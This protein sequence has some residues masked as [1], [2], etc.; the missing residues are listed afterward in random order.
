[1]DFGIGSKVKTLVA[2][3][4]KGVTIAK[5]TKGVVT[6]AKEDGKTET[7]ILKIKPVGSNKDVEIIVHRNEIAKAGFF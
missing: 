7:Y 6:G 5:G 2:F 4:R 1:M 3:K